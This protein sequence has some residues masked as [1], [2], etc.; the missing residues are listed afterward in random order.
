ME[1]INFAT[2]YRPTTFAEVVGQD[3]AKAVLKKIAN[4]EGISVRSIFL[5][6]SWGSGKTTLCRIFSRAMNCEHFRET[7]DV[8]NECKSCKE[9]MA[10]N[11]QLYMEFDSS[12]AGNVEAIRN[13]QERLSYSPNGRRVVVFDEVHNCSKQALNALLKL[14]EDGIPDTIFVF[15]STEDILPTLKSRSL[16]L[17]ISTIPYDLIKE[18]LREICKV[19]GIEA[20]EEVLD[21]VALKSN[22][23]MRDALSILQLYSLAGKD[24][25]KS[26]YNLVV[27]F[28][29]AA[30]SKRKE[31]AE[32]TLSEILKFNIVDVK[33]SVYLFIRN[34][35]VSEPGSE[36][37]GF[38]Q[39]G[40]IGKIYSY[41]F[42]PVSQ[43]ALKDEVGIELFFLSFIDKLCK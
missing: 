12:V 43:F 4:A 37:Y 33:N 35:F 18:R 36:L 30:V 16:C 8:C 9:A 1:S 26:S 15:A 24:G 40:L 27:R 19:Q 3:T 22:G 14:V 31:I 41:V 39:N 11:S 5:K 17:D 34:A 29:K 38:T 10:Q 42:S 13:L 7:G 2:H 25:L 6:G 28:F 20:S 32:Q 21:T 23:H